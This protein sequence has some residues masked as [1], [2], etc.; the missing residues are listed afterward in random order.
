MFASQADSPS[1]Q[2]ILLL[3]TGQTILTLV[4]LFLFLISLELIT[5]ACRELG[6]GYTKGIIQ[7]VGNPVVSLFIGLLATAIIQSSSTITSSLVAMV[8]ANV[9]SLEAAVPAVLGA[10]IG[11]S[12]TS[13][14]VS[15]GH[16][17]SPKAFKRGYMVAS[18]HVI[19]NVLTAILFFPLEQKWK[20]LSQSSQYLA[21]HLS[22]W[23]AIGEG[24]FAF[25]NSLI[26]PVAS[27]L[28]SVAQG[29]P[30]AILGF[31]LV[32]LFMCIFSL[33]ALF[34]YLMLG[35]D[36][37]QNFSRFL[38]N[39]MVSLLSG[40]GITA[41]IHSST[42][43]TSLCVVLA[44]TEKISPKKLF[45]FIL[46]ANVG[47]TVTALMAAIGR[48]ETGLAIALCH[49]LYNVLGV[50]I[51]FPVPV[52]RNFIVH[53]SRWFGETAQRNLSFAFGSLLILF[54]ALPFLV[55]FIFEKI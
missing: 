22:N 53:L 11:T 21:N 30:V 3:R 40:T 10:N 24:W 55:I 9:I 48:S 41:V 35:A 1:R 6:A 47:T 16:L 50:L 29:L 19:F 23:G 45:P 51:F 27:L 37:N 8:A 54:F 4:L 44:A 46:G 32:L 17:G 14:L 42:V 43:T 39:P 31:S 33:T 18:S 2:N 28:K 38:D 26:T 25:N 12:V 34:R 15:F 5:S 13:M 7:V 20:I 52:V 36:R 49:L